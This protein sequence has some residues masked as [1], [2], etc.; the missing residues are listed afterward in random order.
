M[1]KRITAILMAGLLVLAGCTNGPTTTT[2][3]SGTGSDTTTAGG[4]TT[5]EATSGGDRDE[6]VVGMEANYAPYNWAQPTDANGGVPIDGSTSFAGGYDVMVAKALAEHME[7]DL[8]IKQI[9][10]EG[11]IP[12]VQNGSIDLI[13]AGM[14]VTPERAES[15]D[16]SDTYYDSKYVMLVKKGGQYESATS[17][18][19]FSGSRIIGQKSTN[20]DAVIPQIPE[21]QHETPLATVPL[22][23]HAILSDVADGTVVEKPVAISVTAANPDLAMVEFSDENGFQEQEGIETELNI[24]MEKG[25]SELRDQVNEFLS[26]LTVEDRDSMMNEA[27]SNQP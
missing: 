21:V 3:A 19:D 23:I 16:F 22:I 18:A 14:S 8:V 2:G 13:I 20:Y 12:A 6:L 10:W 4:T 25:N 11:L 7:R 9:A 1:R 5:A 26:G 24:A 27:V 15:V 17:L